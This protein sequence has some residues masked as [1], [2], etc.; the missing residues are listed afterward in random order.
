MKKVLVIGFLWPYHRRAG[1]RLGGLVKYLHEFDWEPVL[2]TA[3][4]ETKPELGFKVIEVPY[5]YALD[6]WLKLLRLD[7]NA[8]VNAREQA[9]K[10][11]GGTSKKSVRGAL[12]DFAF[13]RALEII[14]YPDTEKA[15]VRPALKLC[16][17]VW[18]QEK[19]QAIISSSPPV[20]GHIIAGK[21]KTKYQVPWV[22]DLPH[23]W[24]QNNSYAY[25]SLRRM[26]DRKLE[27]KT[28]SL[29]DVLTTTS[30]PLA[31]KLKSLHNDKTV[32]SITHGFD[33]DTV[34]IPADKLTDKFTITYTG[35]FHPV[36]RT[37][38]PLLAALQNLIS[39]GLINREKVEARFFGSE[40]SWIENEI[41]KYGLSGVVKQCGRVTVAVAQ[42][43]QRES[44]LLFNPKW[45]D[46]KEPGIH[47][48][49]LLEY[50]AARRP[51][52]ATGKYPDVADE[53]LAETGAGI[54]AADAV[55]I[56]QTLLEAYREY[57]Q[58]GSVTWHGDDAIINGYSQREMARKFASVLDG[59]V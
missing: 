31:S 23:L 16:A 49:K 18:S 5:K 20:T 39:R 21:L 2:L 46:P 29:A 28:L 34:N 54:Y 58:K 36:L 15:W 27:R 3:P 37:P 22:A 51:V 42:A 17:R 50:L 24:S 47:S 59:L 14:D 4:L 45:D 11:I 19:Y 53:L 40:E 8:S 44:Q 12:I 13:T 10:R 26:V 32:Y 33:P 48:L 55:K 9:K 30:G 1:A 25:S 43:K 6:L 56:E 57:Q 52:L 41:K 35:G 7:K 38:S